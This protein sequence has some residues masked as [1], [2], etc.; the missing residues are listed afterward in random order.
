M[1]S[2]FNNRYSNNTNPFLNSI[3]TNETG[4]SKFS[5]GKFD[6]KIPTA[7]NLP[8]SDPNKLKFIDNEW[9]YF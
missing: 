3:K 6:I 7:K 5:F 8:R 4:T 9:K 1:L 2:D